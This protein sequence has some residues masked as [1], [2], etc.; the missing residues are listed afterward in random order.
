MQALLLS[1]SKE[2]YSQRQEDTI[3]CV[4]LDL[5]KK[6]AG[7]IQ[8]LNVKSSQILFNPK[9]QF[10][11]EGFTICT[12]LQHPLSS[13]PQSEKGKNHLGRKME[14]TLW[15]SKRRDPPPG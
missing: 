12:V 10:S 6:K 13:D 11:S 1:T 14:E 7:L 3:H 2:A 15:K 4:C 5:K 9:S 8:T